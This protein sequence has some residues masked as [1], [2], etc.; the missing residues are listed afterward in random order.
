M[1]RGRIKWATLGQENT[2]FFHVIGTI[3]HNKNA[4]M[5]LKN[6]DGLE[7]TSH[8]DK[9]TIIWETFKERMGASEFSY[10]YFN[11]VDLVQPVDNLEGLITPFSNE[12]IDTIV[13]N[14]KPRKSP[15]PDGFNSDFI[16]KCWGIVSAD[17]YELCLQS[18]NNSF[19]VLIPKTKNPSSVSDYMPISLLNTSIKLITKVLANRLQAVIQRVIHQNQYGFIRKRN[20]QDCLAWAFEYLHHCHRSKKEMVILKLVFEKAFDKVEHKVIIRMVRQ[21]GFP[22]KW[23]TWIESILKFGTSA[24][25]LN[26]TLGKTF[27]CRRGVRQGDPL[28]PLL[29]VL[30]ADMLQSIKLLRWAC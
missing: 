25:L 8:E 23:T 13:K 10:I 11:L 30:A 16:K 20:I 4:I 15:G 6:K 2:R 29:F 21:K 24:A 22:N 9:A 5:V 17:F 26:G 19:I 3:R 14:L 27:H 18:I 12:E 7:K 28:S 1:Q